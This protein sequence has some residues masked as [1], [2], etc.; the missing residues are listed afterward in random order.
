MAGGCSAADRRG[1]EGEFTAPRRTALSV[2]AH[3][4]TKTG[5]RRRRAGPQKGHLEENLSIKKHFHADGTRVSKLPR[6]AAAQY[7]ETVRGGR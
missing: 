1:R 7:C 3:E 5:P 2:R 6:E 4:S